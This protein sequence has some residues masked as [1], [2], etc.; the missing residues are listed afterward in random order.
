MLSELSP[1]SRE[2]VEVIVSFV[3]DTVAAA[4]TVP[5][6]GHAASSYAALA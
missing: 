2:A 4:R 3:T 1:Q 6:R 5:V